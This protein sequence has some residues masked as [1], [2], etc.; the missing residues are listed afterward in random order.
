MVAIV[1]PGPSVTVKAQCDSVL[2]GVATPLRLRDNVMDF[3]MPSVEAVAYTAMGS[4]CLYGFGFYDGGKWHSI[5][6]ADPDKQQWSG[7]NSI[8]NLSDAISFFLRLM[9]CFLTLDRPH[10]ALKS[11]PTKPSLNGSNLIAAATG[12]ADVS[13]SMTVWSRHS[14]LRLSSNQLVWN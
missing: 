1:V 14:H 11:H 13:S 4:R 6:P 8:R 12:H 2:K 7:L 5:S 3:Q 10:W 9:I